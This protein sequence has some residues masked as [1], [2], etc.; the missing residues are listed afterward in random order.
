MAEWHTI[1]YVGESLPAP[2]HRLV[3]LFIGWLQGLDF[4]DIGLAP[5][6][7]GVRRPEKADEGHP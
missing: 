6:R 7:S 3:L 2:H 1:K 4:E 5:V